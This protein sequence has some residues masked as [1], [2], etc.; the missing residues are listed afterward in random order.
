MSKNAFDEIL[1][2]EDFQPHEIFN[3][4]AKNEK[5]EVIITDEDLILGKIPGVNKV[6]EKEDDDL[7]ESEEGKARQAA[8]QKQQKTDTL[9]DEA[10]EEGDFS[11]SPVKKEKDSN[12]PGKDKKP[13]GGEDDT[14]PLKIFY[15]MMVD[16]GLWEED[17]TF[18][19]SEESFIAVKEKNLDKMRDEDL[20][21]YLGQAFEK[22]P[23]GIKY[24]KA[25]LQHLARGGKIADFQTTYESADVTEA[26]LD[27]E[28]TE[29]STS[30]AEQLSRSYLKLIGWDA[31]DINAS[32][33]TKKEKGTLLDFAKENF[34]PYQKKV[35]ETERNRE[36]QEQNTIKANRT[37]AIVYTTKVNDVINSETEVG[38][39]ELPKTP[40]EKKALI[41]YMLNPI[42][43]EDGRSRTQLAEDFSQFSQDPEF[44]IFLAQSLQTWKKKANPAAKTK[45]TSSTKESVLN[46]L[47][48]RK[49]APGNKGQAG[50]QAQQE[51]TSNKEHWDLD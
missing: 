26:D 43:T 20:N 11:K 50:Q 45:A 47:G 3:N 1:L 21:G 25:F 13:V 24:G 17:E 40:K 18:D 38:G 41:G 22:N 10:L 15:K 4:S 32:I 46:L 6:N 12:E 7:D 36:E 39:L 5:G 30:A 37:K 44:N 16:D 31:D 2:D 27:S 19:G 49:D 8:F 23:D 28:D 14:N 51:R 29:V 33:K 9:L 48:G 35:V 42:Q 34:K